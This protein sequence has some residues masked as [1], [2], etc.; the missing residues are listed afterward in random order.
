MSYSYPAAAHTQQTSTSTMTGDSSTIVPTPMK[1]TKQW[2]QVE[3]WA[4][5]KKHL[6]HL[7]LN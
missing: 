3:Q 2:T 7:H 1:Q 6:L 5:H 4:L